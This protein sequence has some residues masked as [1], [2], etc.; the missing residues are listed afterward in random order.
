MCGAQQLAPGAALGFC[1][2]RDESNVMLLLRLRG[3]GGGGAATTT[4]QLT[5]QPRVQKEK[6]SLYW[7]ESMSTKTLALDPLQ[8]ELDA[9]TT[10]AEVRPPL[11][12][13]AAF[14]EVESAAG[15]Q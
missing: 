5:V 6:W 15:F 9:S 11:A 1:G 10:I 4:V 8:L 12:G 14:K 13:C 3:G 7:K 2:V